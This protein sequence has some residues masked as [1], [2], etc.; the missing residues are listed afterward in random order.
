MLP[1]E[2]K[3]LAYKHPQ[4]AEIPSKQ[5]AKFFPHP[6][7]E[8][9]WIETATQLGLPALM[10]GILLHFRSVWSSRESVTL[11][12]ELLDKFHIS[13]GVKQRAL[14]SLEEAGLISVFQETGRSPL[15]TLRKV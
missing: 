10:V 4:L 5:V 7:V 1:I 12:K 11:P 9:L 6:K 3:K 13:R 14:K 8:M 15:I 2:E